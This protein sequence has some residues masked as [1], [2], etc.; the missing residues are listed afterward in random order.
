MKELGADEKETEKI[1]SSLIGDDFLNDERF[2]K[3]FTSGKFRI[4]KWGRVKIMLE[5]QKRNITHYCI[6]KGIQEI[7]SEEYI[8]TIRK[9]VLEKAR[10]IKESDK[11]LLSHRIVQYVISRG[12][13]ADLVSKIVKELIV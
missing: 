6:D 2:A 13:E 8:N 10:K 9:I 5:L 3:L 11:F 12:F 4:K 1:I 7:D